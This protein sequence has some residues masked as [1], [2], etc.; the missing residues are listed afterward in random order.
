MGYGFN[1]AISQVRNWA[2]SDETDH[3]DNLLYPCITYPY[4]AGVNR[5]QKLPVNGMLLGPSSICPVVFTKGG[6]AYRP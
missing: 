6:G 1:E 2:R 3:K 5:A 4:N